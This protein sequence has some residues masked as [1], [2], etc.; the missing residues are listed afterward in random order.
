MACVPRGKRSNS[1][2]HSTPL[3]SV[4]LRHEGTLNSRRAASLLVWL[5]EWEERWETPDHPK[6]F[7]PL[8][9]DGTE[10]NRTITCIVLKVEANDRRKIS[11]P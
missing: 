7:L 5:V 3:D 10:Q 6:G 11:S 9:W 2:W 8:N 1:Q 4:P